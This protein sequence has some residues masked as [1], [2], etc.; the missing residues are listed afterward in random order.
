MAC[1]DANRDDKLTAADALAALRTAVGAGQCDVCLCDVDS[2]GAVFASDAL[3]ILRAAVGQ[4]V[5][6]ICVPC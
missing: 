3:A 5:D 1:G 6:L 4:A 2:S